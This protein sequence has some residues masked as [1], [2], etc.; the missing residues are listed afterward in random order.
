MSGEFYTEYPE[1]TAAFVCAA[2]EAMGEMVSLDS[3][4]EVTKRRIEAFIQLL[5]HC[6]GLNSSQQ[7]FLLNVFTNGL[8]NIK[9]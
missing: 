6:L 9:R 4:I 7:D 2:A 1:E 8:E 3:D 5:A